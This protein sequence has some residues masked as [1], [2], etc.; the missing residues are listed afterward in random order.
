MAIRA[1]TVAQSGG[2]LSALEHAALCTLRDMFCD[3]GHADAMLGHEGFKPSRIVG[4]RNILFGGPGRGAVRVKCGDA[5]NA[6]CERIQ[7]GKS[8]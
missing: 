1:W 8:V 3:L 4:V 6:R 7:A 5:G 2:E